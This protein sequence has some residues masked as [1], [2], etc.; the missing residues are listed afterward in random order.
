MIFITKIKSISY[1]F[2]FL[3]NPDLFLTNPDLFLTNPDF[4]S[5]KPRLHFLQTPTYKIIFLDLF[6]IYVFVYQFIRILL[7]CFIFI[8]E[9]LLLLLLLVKLA[10]V[11]S[12]LFW[13][14]R[15]FTI[16][17]RVFF[18][19]TNLEFYST[20]FSIFITAS[21]YAS[22]FKSLLIFLFR[23]LEVLSY[24]SA[25]YTFSIFCLFS[26]DSSLTL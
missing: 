17:F 19:L 7:L 8:C 3:T 23:R 5:Y 12:S 18:L 21:M 14:S 1:E 25:L 13:L 9:H 16:S 2:L 11:R 15:S 6:K 26:G 22:F 10:N 20:P 24:P 4:T